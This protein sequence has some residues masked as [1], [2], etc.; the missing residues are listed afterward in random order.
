MFANQLPFK[1]QCSLRCLGDDAFNVVGA[2]H[3]FRDHVAVW[4]GG[5]V[6]AYP[7]VESGGFPNIE[8][9]ALVGFEQIHT[10]LVGQ[11]DRSQIH[12]HTVA[13]LAVAQ[14]GNPVSLLGSNGGD[15]S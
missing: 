14:K 11:V 3:E 9:P 13:T 1:H 8:H 10:G 4:I 12:G 2:S 15:D 6:G 7:L 5:K